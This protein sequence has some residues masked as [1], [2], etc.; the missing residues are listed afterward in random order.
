M[1]VSDKRRSVAAA[2]LCLWA[3]VLTVR[4]CDIMMLAALGTTTTMQN[5][6]AMH[7]AAAQV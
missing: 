1:S 3:I 7:L 2:S 5:R 4:P 6:R